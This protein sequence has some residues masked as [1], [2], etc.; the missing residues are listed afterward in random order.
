M[1]ESLLARFPG[2]LNTCSLLKELQPESF[3]L[4]D[5][6]NVVI[7]NF[8]EPKGSLQ[9]TIEELMAMNDPSFLSLYLGNRT[10]NRNDILVAIKAEFGKQIWDGVNLPLQ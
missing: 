6:G 4:L 5:H 2:H 3:V 8:A 1:I 10:L 9:L 7:L